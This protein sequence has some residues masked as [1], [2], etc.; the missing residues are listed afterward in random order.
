MFALVSILAELCVLDPMKDEGFSG[1]FSRDQ[2]SRYHVS[3]ESSRL[4]QWVEHLDPS[5]GRLALDF[6][7]GSP[8][9]TKFRMRVLM[10]VKTL[11]DVAA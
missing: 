3:Q 8:A 10:L 9:H 1:L 6:L 4:V 7:S 5:F 11:L 2:G